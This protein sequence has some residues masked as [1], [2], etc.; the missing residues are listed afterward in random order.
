[1][2][3]QLLLHIRGSRLL[4][5]VE[6]LWRCHAHTELSLS[7]FRLQLQRL[8]GI[9]QSI[10]SLSQLLVPQFLL[11][12]HS[13]AGSASLCSATVWSCVRCACAIAS[14]TTIIEV[15]LGNE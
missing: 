13:L 14:K 6:L 2:P 4:I 10:F 15:A 1:M 7:L 9:T 11:R 8:Y 12:T 5:V 3:R